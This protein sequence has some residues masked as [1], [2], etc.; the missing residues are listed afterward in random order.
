MFLSCGVPRVAAARKTSSEQ[1]LR[2]ASKIKFGHQKTLVVEIVS[3][4]SESTFA[5]SVV[6]VH[7]AANEIEQTKVHLV[8][9]SQA[10]RIQIC[11]FEDAIFGSNRLL[12]SSAVWRC[13]RRPILAHRILKA[14]CLNVRG[15]SFMI[16]W[17]SS[18][19]SDKRKHLRVEEQEKEEEKFSW[20]VNER[21]LEMGKIER[22][23]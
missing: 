9:R 16:T 1:E 14:Q 20:F 2:R 6:Q 8:T 10:T 4:D 22:K 18:H 21:R 12:V 11:P 19:Q 15:N 5:L 17:F 3:N 13:R 23:R 7:H